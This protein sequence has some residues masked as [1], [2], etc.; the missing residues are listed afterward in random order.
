MKPTTTATPAPTTSATT[1]SPAKPSTGPSTS[2]SPA[3]GFALL[4]VIGIAIAVFAVWNRKD[5]ERKRQE[6][7]ARQQRAD[8]DAWARQQMAIQAAEARRVYLIQQFGEEN[9]A[10]VLRGYLWQGATEAMI[11]AM[12]GQPEDIDTKVMKTKTKDT[13]KYGEIGKNRWWRRETGRGW[14][15]CCGIARDPP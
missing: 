12:L 7:I 13:Y 2:G 9:A 3:T 10:K 8:Y 5:R 14:S 15:V 4:L 1:K 6:I 11:V